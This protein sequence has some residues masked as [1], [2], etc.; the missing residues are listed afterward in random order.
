MIELA[1][2][3]E[4]PPPM[5]MDMTVRE[6]DAFAAGA[7]RRERRES[8]RALWAA[9]ETANFTRAKRM[10][11]NIASRI[12]AILRGP[13]GQQAEEVRTVIEH[14]R[15]AAKRQGLGPPKAKR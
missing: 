7:A 9:F 2:E 3:M 14:M 8:A 13:G 4:V 10:P 1:G 15:I 11:R 6:I 5:V 12:R